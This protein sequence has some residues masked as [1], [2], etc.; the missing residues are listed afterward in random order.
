MK[1]EIY[2][3]F[4]SVATKIRAFQDGLMCPAGITRS[5]ANTFWLC[6]AGLVGEFKPN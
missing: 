5:L 4:A 3:L 1:E 6:Q 2:V